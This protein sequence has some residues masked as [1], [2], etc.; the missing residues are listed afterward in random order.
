M[1]PLS[2]HLILTDANVGAWK[3][4]GPALQDCV[5]FLLKNPNENNRGDAALYGMTEKIPNKNV[6]GDFLVTYLETVLDTI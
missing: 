5:D 4:F 2:S 3:E 6:V 1:N